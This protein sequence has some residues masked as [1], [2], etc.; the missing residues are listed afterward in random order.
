MLSQ[1]YSD[2]RNYFCVKAAIDVAFPTYNL[3]LKE[4]T[5]AGMVQKLNDEKKRKRE[6]IEQASILS[7]TNRFLMS[8]VPDIRFSRFFGSY[9]N[10]ESSRYEGNI[11][12]NNN[13]IRSED[14]VKNLNDKNNCK[15]CLDNVDN[16]TDIN[17]ISMDIPNPCQVDK[18]TGEWAKKKG[19]EQRKRSV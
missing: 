8:F 15:M 4:I 11:P 19:K 18:M 6:E 5:M 10:N 1:K 12:V 14:Q 2:V 16:R 9:D 7:Q 13:D 17:G 3:E